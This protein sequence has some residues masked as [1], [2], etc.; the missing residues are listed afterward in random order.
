MIPVADQP[1]YR[2]VLVVGVL[3]ARVLIVGHLDGDGSV[4]LT[5]VHIDFDAEW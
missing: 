3:V 5:S 4:T 1:D 2:A